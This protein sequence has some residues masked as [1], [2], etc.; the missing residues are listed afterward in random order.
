MADYATSGV[1]VGDHVIAAL[2]PR[3]TAAMVTTSPQLSRMPDGC[4]VTVI[5]LVIARQRPGT[6]GGTTFLLFED[7]WGTINLIVPRAR[8][9]APPPTRAGGAAAA[10][11]GSPGADARGRQR[12]RLRAGPARGLRLGRDRGPRATG[13]RS[14]VACGRAAPA[15]RGCSETGPVRAGRRARIEHAGRGPAHAELRPRQA[16]LA[17]AAAC[18]P[19]SRRPATYAAREGREAG[20]IPAYEALRLIL[21]DIDGTLVDT[22]GAGARSWTWAFEHVF[23]KPGVDIGRYSSAGMTDPQVARGTFT[24]GDRPR[25]DRRGARAADARP[26]CPCC[27]TTWPS[28][29][30]TG[31]C[32]A[33]RTCLARLSDAGHPARAHDRGPRGGSPREARAQPP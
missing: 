6:A 5:G 32:L 18:T 2:R 8:L 31:F 15:G 23:D 16:P 19:A 3:L 10:G 26:T 9:R 29:R 30:A 14:C 17:F 25:A 33:S 7:E 27:R 28:R 20:T 13:W 4:S 24:E 12:G 22:G 11:P 1:T 21:F